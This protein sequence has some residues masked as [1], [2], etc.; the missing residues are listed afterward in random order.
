MDQDGKVIFAPVD[1]AVLWCE[2][3]KAVD[4]GLARSI[5]LSNFNQQQIQHVLDNCRIKPAILQ[6]SF[7]A[8]TSS[9]SIVIPLTTFFGAIITGPFGLFF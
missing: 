2:L 4:Q 7:L 9:G 3:E 8:A 1:H 5:G 6:V